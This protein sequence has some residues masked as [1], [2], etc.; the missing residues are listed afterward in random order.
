MASLFLP[1]VQAFR[2][3]TVRHERDIATLRVLEALRIHAAAQDGR[4]PEKLSDITEVPIP[5]DPVSGKPFEYRLEGKTAHLQGPPLPGS[6]LHFEIT[7]DRK[8]TK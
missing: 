1:A 2:S 7:M 3:A 4:L 5:L 8:P 6:P